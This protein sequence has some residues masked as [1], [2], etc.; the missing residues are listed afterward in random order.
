MVANSLDAVAQAMSE[1][2]SDR[3]TPSTYSCTPHIA[4]SGTGPWSQASMACP[5][6]VEKGPL[7]HSHHNSNMALRDAHKRRANNEERQAAK[8][9]ALPATWLQTRHQ[10]ATTCTSCVLQQQCKLV[11]AQ[12][13]KMQNQHFCTNSSSH[14]QQ[15][16]CNQVHLA[17]RYLHGHPSLLLSCTAHKR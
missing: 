6:V 14:Q 13:T 3:H 1:W 12:R 9:Q 16:Y 11:L 2:H 7:Q 17:K 4:C 15:I 8:Q 10:Y 5:V